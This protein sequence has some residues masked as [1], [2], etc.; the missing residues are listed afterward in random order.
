MVKI[1]VI[2][3]KLLLVLLLPFVLIWAIVT[4]ILGIAVSE[5]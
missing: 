1:T 4:D 2:L 3:S 5:G